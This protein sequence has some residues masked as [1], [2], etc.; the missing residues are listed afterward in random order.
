MALQFKIILPGL[1]VSGVPQN[2]WFCILGYNVSQIFWNGDSAI[3]QYSGLLCV[4]LT[5]LWFA[6]ANS[7]KADLFVKKRDSE[8]SGSFLMYCS[9]Y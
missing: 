6:L 3:Y 2:N 9:V 1:R 7:F 5:G 4:I 8:H